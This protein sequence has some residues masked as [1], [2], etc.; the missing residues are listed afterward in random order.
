M[1][2]FNIKVKTCDKKESCR[3]IHTIIKELPGQAL[4]H[5]EIKNQ[6]EVSYRCKWPLH[7]RRTL[8]FRGCVPSIMKHCEHCTLALGCRAVCLTVTRCTGSYSTHTGGKTV[9]C[10]P[11]S[12]P[13]TPDID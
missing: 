6:G 10:F 13:H 3:K 5:A 4:E 1:K 2:K 8:W 9:A 12:L 11:D 7:A